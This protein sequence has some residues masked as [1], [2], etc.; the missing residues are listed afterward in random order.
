MCTSPS[1][2]KLKAD[3]DV[4]TAVSISPPN[5]FGSPGGALASKTFILLMLQLKW[6]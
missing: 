2:E 5:K 3:I 1:G 4:V 6:N